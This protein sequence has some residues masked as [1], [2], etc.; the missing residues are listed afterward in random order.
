MV[1]MYDSPVA[2]PILDVL[3]SN[4]MSQYISAAKEQYAEGMAEQEK[5]AKEFGDLYSPSAQLNEAYYNAT[6]GAVNDAM[7]YLYEQGIDPVRSQEGRAYIQKVIRER[8]YSDIAKWKAQADNMNAYR[9]ASTDMLAKGQITQDQLDYQ[10]AKQGL[11]FEKFNP[12]TDNW[13]AVAPTQ[14]ESLTDLTKT[15]Y[16]ALKPSSLT[17]AQVEAEGLQYDPRYQYAG[18][19]NDA[20]KQTAGVAVPAVLS[21]AYGDYYYD[22]AKQELQA[23]GVKDPTDAQVREQLQ[24]TVA[25]IWQGKRAI[26]WEPDKYAAMAYKNQLDASLDTIKSRN[27]AMYPK[28]SSRSSSKSK[29]ETV[30]DVARSQ[31]LEPVKHDLSKEDKLGIY[32]A[33]NNTKL[34]TIGKGNNTMDII[35]FDMFSNNRP[36]LYS[37]YNKPVH[38]VA[39]SRNG[40]AANRTAADRMMTMKVVSGVTYQPKNGKYYVRV[41]ALPAAG[42]QKNESEEDYQKR[43]SHRKKITG[44]KLWVE[45]KQG[46]NA[47]R[48]KKLINYGK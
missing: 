6:K 18:I 42:K 22:K 2:V 14:M 31:P 41:E 48:E 43:I 12:Y 40:D 36:E 7:N 32:L 29:G 13:T 35:Q 46:F 26:D 23:S 44:K 25:G 30:F 10:M 24:N 38:F 3:D 9:K 1:G 5:F 33:D 11:D 16:A 34:Q 19:T 17:K 8:P 27:D 45:V 37:S 4:M 28:A 47:K 20:I 15:P 39:N 21:S